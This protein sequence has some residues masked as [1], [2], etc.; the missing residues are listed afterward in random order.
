MP[1]DVSW[2][3]TG[4]PDATIQAEVAR[5]CEALLG[6]LELPER[7]LSV[8]LCD[9]RRIRELN[10]T[11]RDID[12]PTDVLSF[13]LDDAA[14]DPAAPQPPTDAGAPLGDIVIS[15]QT[16][17]RQAQDHGLRFE[18]ELTFLLT[19]GLCHLLGHTHDEAEPAARMREEKSRLL[20]IVAPSVEWSP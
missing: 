15:L 17:R 18:E 10:A 8:L 20:A 12:T 5:V 9:D 6:A 7:E 14:A 3:A 1:V 19:H 2:E 16:A 13:P 11:W 4:E